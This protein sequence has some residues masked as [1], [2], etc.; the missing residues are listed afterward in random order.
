[1]R[2]RNYSL[3]RRLP[4]TVISDEVPATSQRNSTD[5]LVVVGQRPMLAPFSRRGLNPS[6]APRMIRSLEIAGLPVIHPLVKEIDLPR[7]WGTVSHI[8]SSKQCPRNF[9][10][11]PL[12]RARESAF[13]IPPTNSPPLAFPLDPS[14]YR[15]P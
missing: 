6:P 15:S 12:S 9:M 1:M 5:L 3:Y 8:A 11:T 2:G 10:E 14:A 7:T 4:C 13:L